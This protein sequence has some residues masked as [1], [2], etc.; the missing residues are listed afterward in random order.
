[1][2]C[3]IF[4]SKLYFFLTFVFLET[5]L[6]NW[7]SLVTSTNGEFTTEI[8]ANFVDENFDE[9]G[10]ELEECQPDDFNEEVLAQ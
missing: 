7:E 4:S 3:N 8:L 6:K 2:A 10:C 5:V 9:P 1:M